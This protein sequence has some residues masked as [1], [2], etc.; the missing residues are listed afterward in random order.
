MKKRYVVKLEFD[1]GNVDDED[2]MLTDF[3]FLREAIGRAKFSI[4]ENIFNRK[5]NTRNTPSFFIKE[6]LFLEGLLSKIDLITNSISS[7]KNKKEKNKENYRLYEGY[8]D[9]YVCVKNRRF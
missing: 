9:L 5:R 8:Y 1:C 2:N 6:Y 4:E 3:S 7:C